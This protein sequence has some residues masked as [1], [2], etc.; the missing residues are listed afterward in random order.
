MLI[1]YLSFYFYQRESDE[2]EEAVLTVG[3]LELDLLYFLQSNH[4]VLEQLSTQEELSQR[5]IQDYYEKLDTYHDHL[6][7]KVNYLRGNDLEV[8]KE[9]SRN[10]VMI[11]SLLAEQQLLLQEITALLSSKVR[12]DKGTYA[13]LRLARYQVFGAPEMSRYSDQVYQLFT[14]EQSYLQYSSPNAVK[15]Y[16]QKVRTLMQQLKKDYQE[17][18]FEQIEG[19]A[20]IFDQLVLTDIQLG[21]RNKNG[22]LLFVLA[23]LE[24]NI[25]G[26]FN[27]LKTQTIQKA[28]D[29]LSE[30]RSV[31]V[32]LL[33]VSVLLSF[34][35][36]LFLRN[37]ITNPLI[38]LNEQ[39]SRDVYEGVSLQR[40]INVDTNLR[41]VIELSENINRL[42][43]GFIKQ[44]EKENHHLESQ[45]L[46]AKHF[47]L[48]N[49]RLLE[50]RRRMEKAI[51]VRSAF[52]DYFGREL[53]GLLHQYI[54]RLQSKE[55]G[56]EE[57]DSL[58]SD[59][60][61]LKN[62][63]G[64]L[65][66]LVKAEGGVLS[67]DQHHVELQQVLEDVVS[68]CEESFKAKGVRLVVAPTQLYVQ[69]DEAVLKFIYQQFLL[70]VLYSAQ[71]SGGL[72]TLKSIEEIGMGEVTVEIKVTNMM[73]RQKILDQYLTECDTSILTNDQREIVLGTFLS[74]VFIEQLRGKVWIENSSEKMLSVYISLPVF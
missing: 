67:P 43:E 2:I 35:L 20:A 29:K 10:I 40:S 53:E 41:E 59:L 26:E 46:K 65:L 9:E 57:S 73:I 54:Q 23:S 55:E 17:R 4:Q 33:G 39:L 70:G 19:Y 68:T 6:R 38:L 51:Q 13:R 24:E 71:E 74:R 42:K 61:S 66:L 45:E 18:Y 32:F 60:R 56:M 50:D 62:I 63:V 16:S 25:Q 47:Q 37:G 58:W 11:D 12:K 21:S 1:S 27:V 44:L 28:K 52:S 48:S 22:S 7:N 15:K 5:T 36:F 3:Q 64:N 30:V 72:V 49:E 31:Y 34:L 8:L 14:L 69:A